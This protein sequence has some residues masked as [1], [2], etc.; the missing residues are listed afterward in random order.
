MR[1][2]N[3]RRPDQRSDL[4]QILFGGTGWLF[5][6][7][8]LAI[9]MAF[10]VANTVGT[11][12]PPPPPHH[13]PQPKPKVT[14]RPVPALDLKYVNIKL[15]IDPN[16]LLAGSPAAVNA[17]RRTIRG[18]K[19]LASRRAGL[20]LLFGGDN[21]QDSALAESLDRAVH[22]ILAELGK[23]NF[24]FKVAVYRNFLGLNEPAT[25]FQLNIYLFKT[26]ST[27]QGG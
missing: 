26:S 16:G 11:V 25:V 22:K 27:T 18:E 5:A 13:H 17:V 12:R 2:R 3:R 10:L 19:S 15:K 8:M 23:D 9:A 24:V 14:K 20:V 4:G 7:L 6:D 21:P 1:T